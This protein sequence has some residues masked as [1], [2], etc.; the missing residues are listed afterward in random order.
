MAPVIELRD[1]T[2]RYVTGGTRLAAI[3]HVDLTVE[4]GELVAVTGPSG[5]GKTTLLSVAGGLERTD[6]GRVT[7][8]GRDLGSAAAA[9]LDDLRLRDVGWLFQSPGLLPVL[10]A[11]ENVALP[12]QL[13]GQPEARWRAAAEAALDAVGL[14]DRSAHRTHELSGGEQHRVALARALA[15][16]P[17]VLLADEPTSELDTETAE[18]VAGVLAAAAARGVAVLVATHD[19]MLEARATRVLTI[20]DGRLKAV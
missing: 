8:L 19:E 9:E 16:A 12:L 3:S 1:V 20:E 7:V 10:T 13:Q 15:K 5:S 2:R 4:E 17:R 6:E 11:L 14:G 18:S